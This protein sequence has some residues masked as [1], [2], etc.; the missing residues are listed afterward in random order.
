MP[1]LVGLITQLPQEQALEQLRVMVSTMCHEDF[2]VAG[3]ATD[4]SLGVYVGWVA[5]RGSSAADMPLRNGRHTVTMLFSGEEFTRDEVVPSLQTRGHHV[6]TTGAGYLAHLYEESPETFPRT[7]NGRFHGI[8]LDSDRRTTTLFVDR[9]ALQRLYFHV[10]TDAFYFAAEAKAILAVRP[11]LRVLDDRGAAELVVNGCVLEDRTLFRGIEVL[12]A[13]AAWQFSGRSHVPVRHR[14]FSP[15]EWEQQDVLD[16]EAYYQAFR[17]VFARRVAPYF[18]ADRLAVSLTGGL[19]SRMLLAWHTATPQSVPCYTFAGPFRDS[20][21]VRVARQVSRAWGQPHHVIRLGDEF[22]ERFGRFAESAVYLT[23]GCADVSRAPDLYVNQQARTI[24][25]VRLTG[26]Y[27]GEVLRQVRAFKP[28]LPPSQPFT[29]EFARQMQVATATYDAAA[30]VQPLSFAVF[31][32]APWFHF[33]L[34]ALEQTQLTMR[35]PFLDDEIV[36]LVYRAPESARGDAFSWRLIADGS[37]TLARYPTDRG[38]G[39]DRNPVHAALSRR[40]LHLQFKA[41]Y[42]YDYGMPQWAVPIDAALSRMR[43]ERLFLG[44]HKFFHFRVWYRDQLSN[45]VRDVLLD[46]K[47]LTRPYLRGP[48]VRTIVADHLR[49]ARNATLT[50]HKLLTLEHVQRLLLDTR[51][52]TT[53]RVSALTPLAL[54][55]QPASASINPW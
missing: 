40:L 31:R 17:H 53:T 52:A 32:Q 29:T 19:D 42:A 12:P 47:A 38:I 6:D 30:N 25:P 50:I 14:Y 9:Y 21:D 3:L 23:D 44:R 45:Y 33:G 35:T 49:G 36:R 55:R 16:D 39:G 10:G 22:L 20:H 26:N 46:S 48:E 28:V 24:A 8:V 15:E 5:L 4:S 13:A 54:D 27:G 34:L 51:P 7:L 41:E 37:R 11:E 18:N 2:Y 43:P 1:G